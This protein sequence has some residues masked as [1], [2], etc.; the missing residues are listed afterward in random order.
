VASG[1]PFVLGYFVPCAEFMEVEWIM[2]GFLCVGGL[3]L[4][5]ILFSFAPTLESLVPKSGAASIRA[6]LLLLL[7]V[8]VLFGAMWLAFSPFWYAL[9]NEPV[10]L[11]D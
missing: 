4:L 9:M 3:G 1:M 2:V 5:N 10:L 7:P 6:S 11:C 8:L